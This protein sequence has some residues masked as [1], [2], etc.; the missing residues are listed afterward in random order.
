MDPSQQ[1]ASSKSDAK[2]DSKFNSGSSLSIALS[3]PVVLAAIKV[4]IVVG[5]LLAL[6][7]HYDK[8]A[9]M[10][11]QRSDLAKILLTYLVPYGVSTWSAVKAL[12]A[13]S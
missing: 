4:A 6:I 5:S 7:N 10:S 8:L 1:P 3:R 2:P 9:D 12:Q 13:R 11:F